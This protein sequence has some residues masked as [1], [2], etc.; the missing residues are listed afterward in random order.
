MGRFTRVIIC[1][2]KRANSLER[3][4]R[5]L[6]DQTMRPAQFE[7]IGVDDCFQEDTA[8]VYRM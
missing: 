6:A 1:T 5:S 2:H 8:E 4:L 3:M 7:V